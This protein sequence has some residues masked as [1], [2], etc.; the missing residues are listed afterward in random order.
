MLSNKKKEETR[1]FMIFTMGNL[2][3]ALAIDNVVRIIPIPQIHRSGDKLLGIA[4]YENQEVLVIDLYKH[5]YGQEIDQKI[6]ITNKGFLVIFSKQTGLYGITIATL[7]N[8][9]DVPVQSVQPLPAE[10][11]DRDSLGIASHMM[12]ASIKKSEPQTV[13]LLDTELLLQLAA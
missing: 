11:R 5:I 10:Y 4:T 9:E 8:V 12:Q 6:S 13:F 3:F 1:K 7:P 2:N